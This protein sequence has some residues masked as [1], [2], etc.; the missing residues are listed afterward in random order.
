MPEVTGRAFALSEAVE[1]DP[2]DTREQVTQQLLSVLE[3]FWFLD[4]KL[5]EWYERVESVS[6]KPLFQREYLGAAASEESSLQAR[7]TFP[8]IRTGHTLAIYWTICHM[9]YERMHRAYSSL[10]TATAVTGIGSHPQ[11]NPPALP[12]RTNPTSFALLATESV[13]YFLQPNMRALGRVIAS[14]PTMAALDFFSRNPAPEPLSKPKMMRWFVIQSRKIDMRGMPAPFQGYL[15][16]TAD[17]ASR[18]MKVKQ[19]F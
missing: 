3:Q 10:I 18:G 6:S 15:T 13:E 7:V 11:T 5:V 17:A 16:K 9:V 4:T 8:D 1:S 14:W 2:A 12:Q 19:E